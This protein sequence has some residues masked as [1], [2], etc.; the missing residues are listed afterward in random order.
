MAIFRS[1]L[2]LLFAL[3]SLACAPRETAPEPAAPAAEVALIQNIRIEHVTPRRDFVGPLPT[4]LEWTEA[5][6]VD[7]YAVSVENDVRAGGSLTSTRLVSM[8]SAKA[9]TSCILPESGF[10]VFHWRDRAG[11]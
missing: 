3:I 9:A 4:K 11:T 2:I 5:A 8:K 7:S 10:Q 1:D 6:G